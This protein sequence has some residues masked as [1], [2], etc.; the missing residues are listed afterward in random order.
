MQTIFSFG[1]ATDKNSMG[2]SE[3]LGT[4]PATPLAEDADTHEIDGAADDGIPEKPAEAPEKVSLGKRKRSAFTDNDLLAFTNMTVAV[5]DVAEAIRYNNPINIHPKFYQN[6]MDNVGF[7]EESLMVHGAQPPRRPQGPGNH[8]RWH[9]AV[10]HDT[11]AI[12]LPGQVLLQFVVVPLGPWGEACMV[13]PL[14][15]M[16]MMM[17]I[18]V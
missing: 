6:F 13:V 1:L 9:G 15:M 16:M 7:S 18:L 11:M 5:K 8:I 12:D 4:A 2:S 3:A 17:Y 10:T 14:M